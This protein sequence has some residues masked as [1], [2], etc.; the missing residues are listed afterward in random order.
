MITA[1]YLQHSYFQGASKLISFVVEVL[2]TLSARKLVQ[3]PKSSTNNTASALVAESPNALSI[4]NSQPIKTDSDCCSQVV[5]ASE[6]KNES[7]DDLI[8]GVVTDGDINVAPEDIVS[9][10][11]TGVKQR[12]KSKVEGKT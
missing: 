7:N 8:V 10:P 9:K 6:S 4:D 12:R 5:A 1:M 2:V 11:S 3:A